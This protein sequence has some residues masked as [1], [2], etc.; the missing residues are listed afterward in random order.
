MPDDLKEKLK[1]EADKRGVSLNAEIILRLE[2]SLADPKLERLDP[3]SAE[4][5]NKKLEELQEEI[6]AFKASYVEASEFI[7]EMREMDRK[8]EKEE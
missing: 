4:V 7:R 5:L 1:V 3:E 2:Q 8:R 6:G